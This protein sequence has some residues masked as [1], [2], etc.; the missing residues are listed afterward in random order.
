M[1]DNVF[2]S[3]VKPVISFLE[4]H[5]PFIMG[6][7][8]NIVVIMA[9]NQLIDALE[10]K[11]TSRLREKHSDSSLV[12]LLP[13]LIKVLKAYLKLWANINLLIPFQLI[14]GKHRLEMVFLKIFY[15]ML[16]SFLLRNQLIQLNYFCLFYM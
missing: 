16:F 14:L 12:N 1:I 5:S 15:Y 8:I 4:K 10:A 3:I 6:V 2:D 9:V 11:L 13:I 7:I